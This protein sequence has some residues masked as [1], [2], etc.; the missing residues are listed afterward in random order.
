[1]PLYFFHFHSNGNVAVDP[2]GQELPNLET[3]REEAIVGLREIA[4]DRIRS[5]EPVG[6]SNRMEIANEAGELLLA[7]S[8]GDAITVLP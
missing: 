8:F 2:E 7:V 3:A 5:G 4:A 6:F 1:M